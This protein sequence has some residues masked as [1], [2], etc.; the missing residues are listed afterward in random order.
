MGRY[1]TMRNKLGLNYFKPE[2]EGIQQEK[3][4]AE[5]EIQDRKRRLLLDKEDIA[6]MKMQ[7]DE[8]RRKI[9][10]LMNDNKEIKGKRV[11]A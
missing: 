4:D 3:D 11:M 2:I 8:Y 9:G 6:M 1:L 10:K 5:L 7:N